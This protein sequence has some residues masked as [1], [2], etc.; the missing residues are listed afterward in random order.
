MTT[1]IDT[2]GLHNIQTDQIEISSILVSKIK[3]KTCKIS[4]KISSNFENINV[5]NQLDN[6]VKLCK[7]KNGPR[8]SENNYKNRKMKITKI[9]RT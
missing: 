5:K 1:N 4:D 7:R 9:T 3:N 8:S 6:N 2:E